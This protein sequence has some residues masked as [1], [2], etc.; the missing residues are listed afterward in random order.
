MSELY[1]YEGNLSEH[2]LH[3]GKNGFD[4]AD[5]VVDDLYDDDKFPIRLTVYGALADCLS[6]LSWTDYEEKYLKKV[7]YFDRTLTLRRVEVLEKEGIAPAKIIT[8]NGPRSNELLV[9]G[10]QEWIDTT[11]PEPMS[12]DEANRM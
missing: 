5:I 2:Q 6:N 3:H 9:F 11:K 4:Y 12:R 8:T 7:W 10:P 1:K